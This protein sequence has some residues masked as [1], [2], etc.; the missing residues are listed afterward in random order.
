MANHFETTPY[1]GFEEEILKLRNRNRSTTRNRSYMDW[2]YQGMKTR[3][4]PEIYWVKNH[5]GSFIGMASVIYR[6]YWINDNKYELMVLGD[7][8]LDKDYRGTGL[9]DDFFSFIGEQLLKKSSPCALVIPTISARKVLSRNG[10]KVKERLIHHVYW[11]NPFEKVYSFT[12]IKLAA[13]CLCY[14]FC[15]FQNKKLCA[16]DEEGFSLQIVKNFDQLFDHLWNELD[17]SKK[18]L[19]ERTSASLQWRY[20][21]RP[22]KKF[23]I[24][25]F[26]LK[27]QFIAYLISSLSSETKTCF[28]Y[29]Y[30]CGNPSHFAPTMKVFIRHLQSKGGINSIRMSLNEQHPY[31]RQLTTAGF[32]TRKEN[33]LFQIFLPVKSSTLLEGSQWML[34]AGDKD[35]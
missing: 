21:D 3:H 17:K 23:C 2:R 5:A 26:F 6:P 28:I 16:I 20:V 4:Q 30:I 25:K 1:H 31:S 22:G 24:V 9:A 33:D 35:V 11:M 12:K 10:W 13:S 8:S 7:I 14:A 18:C 32:M 15:C 29:D 27:K 19:G 34:S